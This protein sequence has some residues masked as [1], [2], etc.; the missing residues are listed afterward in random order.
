M[1]P[2]P[3]QHWALPV[4]RPCPCTA[5]PITRVVARA[6]AGGQGG[7]KTPY[8]RSGPPRGAAPLLPV[9]ARLSPLSCWQHQLCHPTPAAQVTPELAAPV[10]ACAAAHAPLRAVLVASPRP[11]GRGCD[12]QPCAGRHG[13]PAGAAV[14]QGRPVL[15]RHRP[16]LA[17]P[18]CWLHPGPLPCATIA[19]MWPQARMVPSR[20]PRVVPGA[21][22][23]PGVACP[24][25]CVAG[26]RAWDVV[27]MS[28]LSAQRLALHVPQ[29][30]LGPHVDVSGV[31][32][33]RGRR[34]GVAG[35]RRG[36]P[37]S[38]GWGWRWGEGWRG[39]RG[40]HLACRPPAPRTRLR[41]QHVHVR[42]HVRQRW[43]G[44]PCAGQGVSRGRPQAPPPCTPQPH[45]HGWRGH[46][47]GRPSS[48]RYWTGWSGRS[49]SWRGC[50]WGSPPRSAPGALTPSCWAMTCR[51]RAA[52]TP[53]L[54]RGLATARG[55]PRSAGTAALSVSPV[56]SA[57]PHRAL[58]PG[59]AV[60]CSPRCAGTGHSGCGRCS[61]RGRLPCSHPGRGH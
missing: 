29:V 51:S 58:G 59:A 43:I 25:C 56:C 22:P 40:G 57:R 3:L 19:G 10:T 27:I 32:G 11:R 52:G 55:A 23:P 41:V 42:L 46:P 38:R 30:V 33:S 6:T 17:A 5:T 34:C 9:H 24:L 28:Y 54:L 12:G 39:R 21:C 4:P 50:W 31:G 36:W 8:A 60:P 44:H 47:E 13:A 49:R 15:Q 14:E 20:C 45:T 37:G 26:S 7:H 48:P 61:R 35:G 16:Q 2:H 53:R 1:C 18:C